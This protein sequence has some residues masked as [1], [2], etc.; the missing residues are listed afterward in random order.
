MFETQNNFINN[1]YPTSTLGDNLSI[2]SGAW[3]VVESKKEEP[4]GCS[5]LK[6][7][8]K[9]ITTREVPWVTTCPPA[10]AHG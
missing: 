9:T 2:S 10:V 7:S 1:Y 8:S 6:R 5:K 4:E 3:V